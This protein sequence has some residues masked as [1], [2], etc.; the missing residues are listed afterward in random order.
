MAARLPPDQAAI[1]QSL[2]RMKGRSFSPSDVMEAVQLNRDLPSALRFLTHSC[3]ICQDQVTFSKVNHLSQSVRD[4]ATSVFFV[5]ACVSSF[6]F[7]AWFWI[8]SGSQRMSF[9]VI[10]LLVF[11][12]LC[13]S[14]WWVGVNRYG[15]R[16]GFP[17]CSISLGAECKSYTFS[18]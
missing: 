4:Q 3:P 5:S 6:F 16:Q 11:I 13:D 8:C 14:T 10:C 12:D 17:Y 1:F 18:T 9:G 2:M 7:Y 15:C